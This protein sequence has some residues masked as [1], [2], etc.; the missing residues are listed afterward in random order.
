MNKK[1]T[2]ISILIVVIISIG[3]LFTG[4]YTYFDSIKEKSNEE[5]YQEQ[6]D[7]IIEASKLWVK[8]NQIN[9]DITFSLCELQKNEYIGN[10]IN[11]ITDEY[12]PNDSKI[13]YENGKYTF[14]QGKYNLSVCSN[15]FI[16]IEVD[17]FNNNPINIPN[18]YDTKQIIIKENGD[19]VNNIYKNKETIY[20]IIYILNNNEII[21]KYIIINDTTSPIIDVNL[22]NYNYDKNTNTIFLKKYDVFTAPLYKITDNSNSP[23]IVDVNNNVDTYVAGNYSITYLAKDKNENKTEKKINVVVRSNN[24][25]ENYFVDTNKYTNTKNINLKLKG[26]NTKELCISNTS[27]CNN[28]FDYKENINWTIEN[29]NKIYIYYKTNDNTIH[30]KTIDVYIDTE[31]PNYLSSKKVLYG[32]SYDLINII[33]ANDNISGIKTITT[34]KLKN[35]KPNIL[36][37]NKLNI[38][39]EDNANN[40]NNVDVD[41]ITYKYLKCDNS[42]SSVVNEDGLIKNNNRCIYIGEKPNNYIKLNDELYRI[43]SIEND[44]RI[45]IVK[46][47]N[48]SKDNYDG[49]W[50]TSELRKK[51]KNNN[52]NTTIL[53]NGSF[54]YGDLYNS[55][56]VKNIYNNSIKK[57]DFSNV[58]LLSIDDYLMAGMCNTNTTFDKLL[59]N[60]PCKN[61]N[62]LF[63]NNEFWL[64]NSFSSKPLYVTN[65]G[66]ISYTYGGNKDIRLVLYLKANVGIISGNGS[67]SNPYIIDEDID[68]SSLSCSINTTENFELTKT[69]TV[70]SNGALISFD[71]INF[72]NNNKID[73][74]KSGIITAYIKKENEYNYCS[75]KLYEEKEYRYKECPNSNI[76]YDEWYVVGTSREDINYTITSKKE[77]ETNNLNHYEIVNNTSCNNCKWV[78]KYERK[79]NSCSDFANATWSN[80]SN[81]KPITNSIRIIDE[82]TKYGKK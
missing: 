10:L 64:I 5:K 79:P 54:Y 40:K 50:Y 18:D 63:N 80:W 58:G 39:I 78:T 36:G 38:E 32:I 12:I 77:A 34:N 1:G 52:I 19:I 25:N 51:L 75:I 65:N 27:I 57:I 62:W 70:N 43:I 29:N 2:S 7:L 17:S 81:E 15:E 53:T 82:R 33:N 46:E 35:Y 42:I 60:N 26:L 20:E 22:N 56:D 9:A 41:I 74:S 67:Y 66:N 68:I 28:W 4:F 49:L 55:S 44:N 37:L 23:L 61:N 45:K 47:E 69:L 24:E 8:N 13:I 14:K 48:T 6:I 71:G 11:P 76:A 3:L 21:T 59:N 30:M 16:Y 31:K 73:V 72:S